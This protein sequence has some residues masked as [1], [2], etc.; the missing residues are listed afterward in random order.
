MVPI[1]MRFDGAANVE[2]SNIVRLPKLNEGAPYS[3]SLRIRNEDLSYRDFTLVDNIRMRIKLRPSDTQDLMV[4][5]K[6]PG[7]NFAV[8]METTTGDTLT[9][10]ISAADWADIVL[11]RS[12]NHMEMDVPFAF[13]IEFLTSGG[14]VT[15][16]FAHGSGLISVSL[17]S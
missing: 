10:V 4:L 8:S 15:E 3:F 6:N 5:T 16:R 13:V 11:P 7:N 12:T 14:A 2:G 9:I 1:N 17:L